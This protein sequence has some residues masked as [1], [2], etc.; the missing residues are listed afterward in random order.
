MDRTASEA[1]IVHLCLT[2]RDALPEALSLGVRA[3]WFSSDLY[4]EIWRAFVRL[5][6]RGRSPD[7]ATM[8]DRLPRE[9]SAFSST[10]EVAGFFDR[11]KGRYS[12]RLLPQYVET[13]GTEVA[14]SALVHA[15]TELVALSAT[16]SLEELR[17]IA[18]R[19]L[20]VETEGI[21]ELPTM[22]GLVFEASERARKE[23]RGESDQTTVPTSI[24]SLDRRVRMKF[25]QLWFVGARPSMGKTHFLLSILGPMCRNAGTPAVVFSVEMAAAALGD[26]LVGHAA[27]REGWQDDE[28]LIQESFVD[29][30]SRWTDEN[31]EELPVYVDDRTID[32]DRI[33]S[34]IHVLRRTKGA[35]LFVVDYLQLVQ[36]RVDRGSSRE[37][38]VATISRKLKIAAKTTDSLVI[39]AAQLNRD[40]EKR[41]N[42]RPMMSD[43]RDSG[44]VEQ[45]ADGILFLYRDVVYSPKTDRPN[46]LEVI[47]GKQRQG[48]RGITVVLYYRPGDGFVRDI[49]NNDPNNGFRW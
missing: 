29:A 8:L 34:K 22:A 35:R 5:H 4:S 49:T 45:D 23:A 48:A 39:C 31:G 13:L 36:V 30:V 38:A 2:K 25:G 16:A 43:L 11:I 19:G 26:R 12:L 21:E 1:A 24:E 33:V 44:Q 40:C 15:A 17:E 20:A 9:S 18:Q 47:V 46:D 41:A 14:R 28:G 6:E 3:D 10:G 37:Q 32:I 27:A 42:H 7:L